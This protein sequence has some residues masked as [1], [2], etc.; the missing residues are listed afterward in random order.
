[1]SEEK[2]PIWIAGDAA[3]G[4]HWNTIRLLTGLAIGKTGHILESMQLVFKDDTVLII[5]KKRSPAGRQV[6]FLE[7]AT[8]ELVLW[9][10]ASAIKSKSIPWRANNWTSMRSDK[11]VIP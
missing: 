9:V 3:I 8:L 1:M 10:M 5:L 4:R 11:S 7:A 2:S 6:A